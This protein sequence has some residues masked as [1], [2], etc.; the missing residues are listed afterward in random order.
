MDNDWLGLESGSVGAENDDWLGLDASLSGKKKAK[1]PTLDDE[2]PEIQRYV[3]HS[4]SNLDSDKIINQPNGDVSTVLGTVVNFDGKE[5]LVPTVWD[6]RQL[7][8][9]E[10][11][12]RLKKEGG[13]W[14]SADSVDEMLST[15]QRI[16]NQYINSQKK[17]GPGKELSPLEVAGLVALTGKQVIKNAADGLLNTKVSV[18]VNGDER[19]GPSDYAKGAATGVG[20][21]L[22]GAGWLVNRIGDTRAGQALSK[23]HEKAKQYH[24]AVK[25]ARAVPDLLQRTVMGGQSVE[26]FGEEIKTYWQGKMS[27]V[28]REKQGRKVLGRDADG[29]LT[30][31]IDLESIGLMTAGSL[32]GTAAGMGA[33]AGLSTA[34]KMLPVVGKT[35]G[36][37]LGFSIGEGIV[38]APMAG[39]QAEDTIAGMT[40]EEMRQGVEYQSLRLVGAT[41]E[42][43]RDTLKRAAGNDAAARAFVAT[44]VLSAPFGRA[45]DK[46]FNPGDEAGSVLGAFG[47]GAATEALQE[48]PQSAA[49]QLAQNFAV[50]QYG[51][52]NQPLGENVAES[53]ISGGLSGAVMGGAVGASG[54]WDA[55]RKQP[56]VTE[57]GFEGIPGTGGVGGQGGGPFGGGTRADAQEFT[58]DE[59]EPGV[60]AWTVG[61]PRIDSPRA[62]LDVLGDIAGSA[63]RI[64]Q[65]ATVEDAATT[66]LQEIE[67]ATAAAQNFQVDIPADFTLED[68][69]PD[70]STTVLFDIANVRRPNGAIG[71]QGVTDTQVRDVLEHAANLVLPESATMRELVDALKADKAAQDRLREFN[72]RN[73]I[74]V[75]TLPDGTFH[76]K[77]GHHRT[78]L[79]NQLGDETIPANLDSHLNNRTAPV[80]TT[81]GATGVTDQGMPPDVVSQLE[82]LDLANLGQ[83]TENLLDTIEQQHGAVVAGAAEE[84]LVDRMAGVGV[85]PDDREPEKT[86][87]AK[88]EVGKTDP[89]RVPVDQIKLSKDVPQFK[90][91]ADPETGV[92]EPLEG[93]FQH[94]GF[95]PIMVWERNNGDLEVISGRHRLDIARRSGE[96]DIL[97]YVVKESDGFSKQHAISLDAKLNIRDNQ[98]EVSDYANYFKNSGSTE[99]QVAADGLLGRAKGRQGWTIASKGGDLLYRAHQAGELTDAQADAIASAAPGNEGLQTLGMNEVRRGASINMAVGTMQAVQAMRAMED[100]S[101]QSDMFGG[102]GDAQMQS[103]KAIAKRVAERKRNLQEMISAAQ[104]AAKRPDKAREMGITVK[105]ADSIRKKIAELKAQMAELDTWPTNPALRAELVG[106]DAFQLSTENSDPSVISSEQITDEPA[107]QDDRTQSMFGDDEE[108]SLTQETEEQRAERENAPQADAAPAV[109]DADTFTLTTGTGSAGDQLAP[110]TGAQNDL[111][112]GGFKT[113][114]E[115]AQTADQGTD[116]RERFPQTAKFVEWALSKGKES[117]SETEFEGQKYRVVTRDFQGNIGARGKRLKDEFG[118]GKKALVST[119]LHQIMVQIDGP[120]RSDAGKVRVLETRYEPMDAAE[121]PI[122]QGDVSPGDTVYYTDIRDETKRLPG[123]FRG[124]NGDQVVIVPEGGGQMSLP[125]ARVFKNDVQALAAEIDAKANAAASSPLNDRPD[126]TPAQ[127][128]ADNYKKGDPFTLHGQTIVIEN[129]RDSLRGDKETGGKKWQNKMAA[130]YG[131]IKGTTAADGDNLDVFVGQNPESERI[132]IIDQQKKNG[133]QG[134]FDEHKVMMGF[135]DQAAAE[136]AYL[137]S[138]DKGWGIGP[139]TEVTPQELS[140]WIEN[141]DLSLPVSAQ[142]GTTDQGDSVEQP[143]AE[144]APKSEIQQLNE[145]IRALTQVMAGESGAD[146]VGERKSAY[147]KGGFKNKAELA[148]RVSSAL[149]TIANLES[150]EVRA[151]QGI[152]AANVTG[153]DTALGQLSAGP[154][155]KAAF[156]E[157]LSERADAKEVLDRLHRL[158]DTPW[159][160]QVVMGA[161][162]HQ[163]MKDL[164]AGKEPNYDSPLTKNPNS[165]STNLRLKGEEGLWAYLQNIDIKT[166]KKGKITTKK[167]NREGFIGHP[168]KPVNAVNGP[169]GACDPTWG[170]ATYCYA[171]KGHYNY[172]TSVNKAEA[173]NLAVELDPKRVGQ[174]I[175]AEYKTFAEYHAKK[176]LRFFDKGDLSEAWLPV[177]EEVNRNGIRAQI[178]S[179]RPEVLQHVN[180]MNV[181]MLSIDEGNLDKAAA[182]PDL[183]VALVYDG[184]KEMTDWAIANAERLA[185]I[186]PIKVGQRLLTSAEMDRLWK[187]P[188]TAVRMCPI[189]AGTKS[190]G[191]HDCTKCDSYGGIGCFHKSVTAKVLKAATMGIQSESEISALIEE[192]RREAEKLTEEDRVQVYADMAA[193]LSK[194]RSGA[195]TLTEVTDPRGFEELSGRAESGDGL[196]QGDGSDSSVEAPRARYNPDQSDLFAELEAIKDVDPY[197]T[198][199]SRPDTNEAQRD[200]G[201]D[202]LADFFRW[203]T[204]RYNR[205]GQPGAEGATISLLGA[206]IYKNFKAGKPNQLVGRIARSPG[207]LAALAQVYRDPRFETFRIFYTN[208]KGKILLEKTMTTRLPSSVAFSAD[209][210]DDIKQ[211]KKQL[212][213][214]GYYILHNHPSGNSDPSIPDVNVTRKIALEAPGFQAH[215]VID[216]NEYTTIDL[217]GSYSKTLDSSLN[218]VDF[219]SNPTKFHPALGTEISSPQEMAMVGKALAND[220]LAIII[221]TEGGRSGKVNLLASMPLGVLQN[222]NP[223]LQK[224]HVVALAALRRMARAGSAGGRMFIV[225]PKSAPL[226]NYDWLAPYASDVVYADGLTALPYG[227][228]FDLDE[229]I[230]QTIG[231]KGNRPRRQA[232]WVGEETGA[233][234]DAEQ[235]G[236]DASLGR[237]KAVFK[238][239][240]DAQTHNAKVEVYEALRNGGLIDSQVLYDLKDPSDDLEYHLQRVGDKRYWSEYLNDHDGD[241]EKE[242]PAFPDDLWEIAVLAKGETENV[243]EAGYILPDGTMLDFSGKRDGGEANDRAEDHRQLGFDMGGSSDS[244]SEDMNRFIA[245]GAIRIDANSGSIHIGKLPTVAQLAGLKKV[246]N[247]NRSNELHMDLVDG[248]RTGS[249]QITEPEDIK[250]AVDRFYS[251]G[252]AEKSLV[253]Q[254]RE[255]PTPYGRPEF[256]SALTRAAQNLKEEKGPPARMLNKLRG[257]PGVN[258]E[259]IFWTGLEEFLKL[260]GPQVTKQQIVDYLAENNVRVETVVLGGDSDYAPGYYSDDER[261]GGESASFDSREEATEYAMSIFGI[262]RDEAEYFVADAESTFTADDSTKFASYQLPGGTNYREVLLTL[263]VNRDS[264]EKKRLREILELNGR[265]TDAEAAAWD[266]AQFSESSQVFSSS[267]FDEPN[268]LLHIRMNDRVDADGNR[269]LF[270]E[271]IQSDWAADGRKRGFSTTGAIL[272]DGYKI[273]LSQGIGPAFVVRAPS[274]QIVP[275]SVTRS[276]EDARQIAIDHFGGV[277]TS[278][279]G[280]VPPAPFVTETNDWVRLAVKKILRLAAEGG[281]DKVAWTTGEQQVDRYSLA[282]QVKSIDWER[283]APEGATDFDGKPLSLRKDVTVVLIDDRVL[284]FLVKDDGLISTPDSQLDGKKLDEVIGK[285]A[286]DKI[287]GED[288]GSLSGDGLKI[289]GHG[290]RAFYDKIVPDIIRG[291][292]KKMGGGPIGATSINTGL[293]HS[294][295]FEINETDGGKFALRGRI[296]SSHGWGPYGVYDTKDQARERFRELQAEQEMSAQPSIDITPALRDS[297]MGGQG[298]F[299]ITDQKLGSVTVADVQAIADKVGKNWNAAVTVIQSMDELPLSAQRELRR[300]AITGIITGYYDRRAQKVYIIA[301]AMKNKR[302]AQVTLLHEAVGHLGIE[303]VMGKD[304]NEFLVNVYESRNSDPVIAAAYEYVNR[305]QTYRDAP[306]IVQAAEMVARIAESNPKHN[307]V[308]RFIQMIRQWARKIGFD[309]PFSL[310]DIVEALRRAKRALEDGAYAGEGA[311]GGLFQT[312]YHGSPHRHSKF[313][314]DKVGTGEGSQAFGWG[315]YFAQLK[316]VAEYYREALKRDPKNSVVKVIERI[317]RN[318]KAATLDDVFFE[319]RRQPDLREYENDSEIKKDILIAARGRNADGTVTDEA[320]RAYRRLSD[321]MPTDNGALYTVEVPDND[322]LLDWDAPLSEQPQILNKLNPDAIEIVDGG[323]KRGPLDL[324]KTTGEALYN[325]LVQHFEANLD[326]RKPGLYSEERADKAASLYLKSIGIPGLRFFDHMS[327]NQPPPVPAFDAWARYHKGADLNTISDRDL[328]DLRDEYSEFVNAEDK[329]TRNFVIFDE[330]RIEITDTLFRVEDDD[331]V[332]SEV[333]PYKPYNKDLN[334]KIEAY[335]KEHRS[336]VR[337]GTDYA[338]FVAENLENQFYSVRSEA[339]LKEVAA[340]IVA[341]K[342]VR[343]RSISNELHSQALRVLA[344]ESRVVVVDDIATMTGRTFSDLMAEDEIRSLESR[345]LANPRNTLPEKRQYDL[346]RK[347][348]DELLGG[349]GL[350]EE[351]RGYGSQQPDAPGTVT[352]LTTLSGM[353]RELLK[354]GVMPAYGPNYRQRDIVQ[355]IVSSTD[356][357]RID[358]QSENAA[359][360]KRM[361]DQYVRV[362]NPSMVRSESKPY[363]RGAPHG[364]PP[365]FVRVIRSFPKGVAPTPLKEGDWVTTDNEVGRQYQED[366]AGLDWESRSVA[367]FVPADSFEDMETGW[368]KGQTLQMRTV[369]GVL[370]APSIAN[371]TDTP[372]FKAW[373]RDS[374]VVDRKGSPLLVYHGT[375][376]EFTVFEGRVTGTAGYFT[377]VKGHAKLYGKLVPVYLSIQNPLDVFEFDQEGNYQEPDSPFNISLKEWR[378]HLAGMGV[379]DIKFDSALDPDEGYPFWQLLDPHDANLDSNLVER[380]KAAGYDGTHHA[381][382][383]LSPEGDSVY[384][385]FSPTQ[386]KSATGNNGDFDPE[387]PNILFRVGGQPGGMPWRS[388]IRDRID[389]IRFQIQDKLIDLKRIQE[390]VDP[391]DDANAYQK[392]AIWEGKAG[393]RLND[394]DEDRV[395]PLLEAIAATGI[396]WDE[397]GNWLVARH[398]AE[399]NLYLAEINPD[400]DPAKRYRLSGMSNQEANVILVR[401]GGDQNLAAVGAMIDQINRERVDMLITDGLITPHMASLWWSRYQHYVPLKREEADNVDMLPPRGQ[402]FSIKGKESKMR[403]GS[404]DWTPGKIVA[405]VIAQYE[406]SVVRAEKNKVGQALL[407][408]AIQNPDP[409]FW[410]VDP[411]HIR[412]EVRNGKV[413]SVPDNMLRP[414]ELSVKVAGEQHIIEFKTDNPHATQLVTGLKNL[415]AA[416]MG[417]VMRALAAITR[418]MATINTSWNPEFMVANFARDIQTA[419]YSLSDTDIADMRMR[420][421]TQWPAAMRGIFSALFGDGSHPWAPKWNDFRRHGGKTGWMDIHGDIK[422]READLKHAAERIAAGKPSKGWVRRFVNGVEDMNNVIENAVRL[423]A[424]KNA[425]EV[426]L[427]K[428]RAAALAKDLTV[429]FNRKGNMGPTINAFYMFFN[430]S[431]QGNVRMLQAMANSKVGRR[432]AYAT[433]GFAVILDLINR[434]LSG[435]DDDGENI[436]DAMPDYVKDHNMIL[437]GEKEPIIK[438]PLPWGY[439]ILHTIGQVIG[440]GVWKTMSGER[441]N[442]LE[443]ASRVALGFANA[444]NPMSSGTLLQMLS[445]TITDPLVQIAENKNFAGQPLKPEH[446]FDSRAPRPEYLMHWESAREASQWI[447]KE[448]NDASGGNEIR[449]GSINV[450]PEWIDTILDAVTGGLGASVANTLDTTTRLVTGQE[451][452]T[453]NIP[454]LRRV[455]GFNSDNGLKQRYY[456]WSRGVAY[457][458]SERRLLKDDALIQAQSNPE[459]Q[460]INVY[461]QTEKRLGKLRER[462]RQMEAQDADQAL[463]DGVDA[464]IRASMARFNIQYLEVMDPAQQK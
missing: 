132:F 364:A 192:V 107:M 394:F 419:A 124:F 200:A 378:E 175:S 61:T 388:G 68:D 229:P 199:E 125:A 434:A 184:S 325:R 406:A 450:S 148:A 354:P 331:S 238:E 188:L 72:K 259:E 324:K 17:S 216:T 142:S 299:R 73:P 76:L 445:P 383:A 462:R 262:D 22:S 28:A 158:A 166:D 225:L 386:I 335:A 381:E 31:D 266:K 250:R 138:Y 260:S 409:A 153:V 35:I 52:P 343:K 161:L 127:I 338:P 60:W 425:L 305:P 209:F 206:S 195:D 160:K 214:H 464:D 182:Y 223:F 337:M 131:D 40:E 24:P 204:A 33:G 144:Y 379:T 70:A 363:G 285:E 202:A 176:A 403:T 279:M 75:T 280:R 243:R 122:K 99:E 3:R 13:T 46:V 54:A 408:F 329:R 170:C 4:Q 25:M 191:E 163:A 97:S 316:D 205:S 157:Y 422:K 359:F 245:A 451:M 173:I 11:I 351:T 71:T 453:E 116:N 126:P 133:D 448:L 140:D 430:A 203:L 115:A 463:I 320:M 172:A 156:M 74:E 340:S 253:Q 400:M 38:A 189:D 150:L 233:Y 194:V 100:G 367:Y 12:A 167:A 110:S 395:Q 1:A 26:E 36:A 219:K 20:E 360:I 411:E 339:D 333:T 296:D 460:L 247:Y 267:H 436:Y 79:V 276:E 454:F 417:S 29:N 402:G 67:A 146:G 98:G 123:N 234:G 255:E 461:T 82:S 405:N 387:N 382:G 258:A 47:R 418:F 106:E 390:D 66:A 452:P 198:L 318:A 232:S 145:S 236:Y 143:K 319:M 185:V 311:G 18:G 49:E 16:K 284:Y 265:F 308:Q 102:L 368:A 86:P 435:D 304:I 53:A 244:Y 421:L 356:E 77:D 32:P 89:V 34:L 251:G 426:G 87:R 281:Y 30:V 443:M 342:S 91:G 274:G 283:N 396:P 271:E 211:T 241:T 113:R 154:N 346:D 226:G 92:V 149:D 289:G 269:V 350:R 298:L 345:M 155:E 423:A 303:R 201:R 111:L 179:K 78:F 8:G 94:E 222:L 278:Q 307:I 159:A 215:V 369:D 7:E 165:L 263:P 105:N 277:D 321:K 121:A 293:N 235:I 177:I 361:Y 352:R 248:S 62:Q 427:S 80:E 288:K 5:T 210:I 366:Y 376:D 357:P 341:L 6:G 401:H 268:I 297:V 385:P 39:K 398:A 291:V 228:V 440:E 433:I 23:L 41:H 190:L 227:G 103:A 362:N 120:N 2:P 349:L 442:A 242:E 59:V 420:V 399:A 415:Q 180:P 384:V 428:D 95:N 129:P 374:K 391:D 336:G 455:T 171:T 137:D 237:Y 51:D 370:P 458:A 441:V 96:T 19:V 208:K 264:A 90:E 118:I 439:N 56:L 323:N 330:D 45:L 9:D 128:A 174:M 312:G 130:H 109:P 65:Q 104:G 108:F 315:I 48:A 42:E 273:E 135:T 275:G 84:W 459:H 252:K 15:E 207:D 317:E 239:S 392:A 58:F 119:D 270:V 377:P 373:F 230:G 261:W 69:T 444:F 412:R 355:R 44:V 43:A 162:S 10:L 183:D 134:G 393:E 50:L 314:T 334:D 365:G 21:V 117:V 168:E 147:G 410:E 372:E 196:A 328:A 187:N 101:E 353:A 301:D 287:L 272:P 286:A 88:L 290:M 257:M 397:V 429:N 169:F 449:P 246:L 221:T 186:L 231:P 413:I 254:F 424:Y 432:L 193:L 27:D 348:M 282:K 431:M 322:E 181:R 152:Y 81:T 114:G 139:V 446:T 309:V 371:K 57:P 37:M 294:W 437:M 438:F 63:S 178:F 457:A 310:S 404:A 85:P 256:Y 347:R 300:Q 326:S 83:D 224:Q 306:R 213:A 456:E 302:D 416:E 141:G 217:N 389:R 447:A 358:V 344:T 64:N 332:R 295:Q 55:R 375:E 327:R 240:D 407:E 112:G 14:P 93:K 292:T 380:I 164:I 212:K 197:D 220:D 151:D 249:V 414:N 218:S 313:S 136:K